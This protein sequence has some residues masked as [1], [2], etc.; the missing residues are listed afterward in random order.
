MHS[1]KDDQTVRHGSL[2]LDT[3]VFRV[4]NTIFKVPSRYFHDK[5]AAFG[6][7]SKISHG[8]QDGEGLSDE[9]PIILSPLPHN[10]TVGDFEQLVKVIMALTFNL[11]TPTDYTLVQWVSVLKLASVWDFTDLKKLAMKSITEYKNLKANLSRWTEI[12]DFCWNRAGFSELRELAIHRASGLET[13]DPMTKISMGRKYLVRKWVSAGLLA[14]VTAPGLPSTK[15][16]HSLGI[17]IVVIF[18]CLR[19]EVVRKCPN[20]GQALACD[21]MCRFQGARGRSRCELADI[22]KCFKEE[23]S[24]IV[25]VTG[26]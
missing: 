20:C 22:E 11:P 9:N 10:A 26:K 17:D 18:L 19:D 13:W 23:L 24:R 12:L 7:A 5:S 16:L 25:P 4:E 15:D 2:Y 14:L 1:I 6:A 8:N 3:I 21:G